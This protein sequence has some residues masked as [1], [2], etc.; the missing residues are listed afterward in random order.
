MINNWASPG[1]YQFNIPHHV[2]QW[3]M[4]LSE[5]S[6]KTCCAILGVPQ[7]LLADNVLEVQ[8]PRLLNKIW[9]LSLDL[10]T[11]ILWVCVCVSACMH[12]CAPCTQGGQKGASD[13]LGS[14]GAGN[15][16]LLYGHWGLR[17]SARTGNARNCWAKSLDPTAMLLTLLYVV[18]FCFVFME[19]EILLD[20]PR[21]G[22]PSASASGHS[23]HIVLRLYSWSEPGQQ[24]RRNIDCITVL[25]IC[26]WP[27]VFL[28]DLISLAN[29]R[30]CDNKHRKYIR[31]RLFEAPSCTKSFCLQFHL[32][33]QIPQRASAHLI[34]NMSPGWAP[35]PSS[36]Q[37]TAVLHLF[38][39]RS[40]ERV[41]CTQ[42]L[43]LDSCLASHPLLWVLVPLLMERKTLNSWF[44]Y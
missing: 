33:C 6:P 11:F 4:H 23:Y 21:T 27:W 31:C 1:G 24:R 9:E 19:N 42:P 22:D 26:S 8:S 20:S 17:F 44:H 3:H 30:G 40:L 41:V 5:M 13:L 25:I 29:S 36:S 16:V 18:R 14:G 34:V 12:V 43:H 2:Q 39:V 38:G 7:W 32:L 15:C 35:M 10:F 28:F 37:L